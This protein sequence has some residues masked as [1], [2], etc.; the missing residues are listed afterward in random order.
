MEARRL[1]SRAK[2][3]T[4]A[5]ALR[6]ERD[7]SSGSSGTCRLLPRLFAG[8]FAFLV[9]LKEEWKTEGRDVGNVNNARHK[10]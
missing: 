4:A 10:V 5:R 3:D 9:I 8:T 6:F 2:G 7:T 1:E